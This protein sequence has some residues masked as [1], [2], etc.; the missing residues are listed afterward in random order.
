MLSINYSLI[1]LEEVRYPESADRSL[2]LEKSKVFN[3]SVSCGCEGQRNQS[4][5]YQNT[6]NPLAVS[7]ASTSFFICVPRPARLSVR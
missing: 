7:R 1:V 2:C 5:Y 3:Q 6:E 4:I